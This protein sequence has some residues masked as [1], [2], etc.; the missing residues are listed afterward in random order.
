MG[1]VLLEKKSMEAHWRQHHL[2]IKT[3]YFFL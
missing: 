2:I 1:E 3:M